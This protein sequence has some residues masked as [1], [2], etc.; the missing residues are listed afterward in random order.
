MNERNRQTDLSDP[1]NDGNRSWSATHVWLPLAAV[2]AG[3][4]ISETMVR[5]LAPQELTPLNAWAECCNDLASDV[6]VS[7]PVYGWIA[8]PVHRGE[9]A[10]HTQLATNSLGLRDREY[11]PKRTGEVRILSLGDSYAFG[12]GVELEEAY[13]KMLEAMLRERFPGVDISVISAGFTGYNTHHTMM[14]FARL[15]PLLN[16]DFVI[17]TFVA[18]ND[19]AENAVFQRQ[20]EQRLQSPVGFLGRNSHLARLILRVTFGPRFFA[21]N[22]SKSNIWYTIELLDELDSQLKKAEVPYTIMTIPARHQV[23]PSVHPGAAFV[24]RIGARGYLF[25]QNDMVREHL[26]A[27]GIRH[28]D[29]YPVLA[30][31]DSMEVVYFEDDPHTNALG[32]R[33][34]AEVVFAG[35]HQA[36]L[37][38]LGRRLRSEPAGVAVCESMACITAAHSTAAR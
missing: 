28:L 33:L 11:G 18:G 12:Y 32:H 7:D 8:R 20:L 21:S 38:L 9:Y 5:A 23:R 2:A 16:P 10:R 15:Q 1:P 34:I 19:V 17:A 25:R 27:E 14:E 24:D 22:R 36:V 37:P 4:V 6:L 35:I 26:E 30:G 13:P 29:S 3:L 31:R